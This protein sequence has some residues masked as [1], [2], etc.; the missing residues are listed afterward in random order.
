[1]GKRQKSE[2]HMMELVLKD[3]IR[4]MVDATDKQEI[5]KNR[6]ASYSFCQYS[7]NIVAKNVVQRAAPQ[8]LNIP[9]SS[10]T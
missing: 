1:V 4:E 6:P 8:T 2:S 5:V 3:N 9:S 7:V 10:P